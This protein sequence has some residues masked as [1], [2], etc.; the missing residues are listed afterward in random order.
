MII[1]HTVLLDC[2]TLVI[3]DRPMRSVIEVPHLYYGE[4]LNK[5]NK[6]ITNHES[7]GAHTETQNNIP[8]TQWG[9][10]AT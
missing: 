6:P 3:N 8:Q 2:V 4:T 1:L 10:M 7:S 5:T 9:K